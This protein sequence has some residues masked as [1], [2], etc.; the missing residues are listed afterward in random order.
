MIRMMSLLLTFFVFFMTAAMTLADDDTTSP[1]SGSQL[2]TLV[3]DLG[4]T[5]EDDAEVQSE[6]EPK[7]ELEPER[8]SEAISDNTL[9]EKSKE[10]LEEIQ[11]PSYTVLRLSWK[12]VPYAVKYKVTVE[13]EELIT[14]INS[15]EV[16]VNATDKIFKVIALD[17]DDNVISS[18]IDI[19]EVETNPTV[20][21]TT[22]EFDKMDYAP[23]YP[24]YSWVPKHNADYYQVQLLKDGEVVR[25]YTTKFKDEDDVY[26]FYDPMPVNESGDYYWRVKA[27]SKY[28]F[29][30]S[31]WSKETDSTSFKVK[32]P[33]KFAAFGD[34]ITHGGGAI[35]VPPSI[36]LY[37]WETY[38]DK[39][40]KNLGKSGDTTDQ[41]LDR[42]DTD[43]LPFSPKILVIMAGV[44]DYRGTILGWHTV[45][46]YKILAE[47]CKEHH[48]IPVFVT[49]TPV[50]PKLI[51]HVKFIDPPPYDW[52]TH[53]K[54]A[55]DWIKRQEYFIDLTAEFEDSEGFL[56]ED[57]TTDGL[58]P[59]I[60]GK[61]IIGK[62][63][64]DWLSKNSL[65]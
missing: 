34:S 41:L 7:P 54:Y 30:V 4:S 20:V 1:S 25:D 24:V 52:Q 26:D 59:D 15:I 42:F 45:S 49:P 9:E 55:C 13:G 5:Q 2:K 53:Y 12:I 63:V 58:H 14:Y 22:T 29:A 50:N 44:N 19:I 31:E 18:D 65:F 3:S 64:K 60:E 35:T 37:N 43:V 56:R 36:I 57:L 38:C 10:M 27:M 21:K 48:I 8:P 6:S 62:A 39:P 51:N 11:Q 32:A 46:N 47:K 40:I 23:L 16:P 17:Y 33:V 61:K 28:G